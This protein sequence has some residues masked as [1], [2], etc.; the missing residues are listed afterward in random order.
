MV[1]QARITTPQSAL[2]GL[3]REE[4]RAIVNFGVFPDAD[5]DGRPE[6]IKLGQ[7]GQAMAGV[8]AGRGR[9]RRAE[10]TLTH[11]RAGCLDRACP[12]AVVS[13]G[14]VPD[15]LARDGHRRFR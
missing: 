7:P 5:G 4:L 6:R 2:A 1:R 3:S 10:D 8:D 9:T 12:A 14:G 11:P 15:Q 13:D